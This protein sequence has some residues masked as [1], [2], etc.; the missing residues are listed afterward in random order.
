VLVGIGYALVRLAPLGLAISSP[1][2]LATFVLW[3]RA[4]GRRLDAYPPAFLYAAKPRPT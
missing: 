2:F 3:T 4:I 1:V